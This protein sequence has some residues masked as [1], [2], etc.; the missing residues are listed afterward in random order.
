MK[1]KRNGIFE[2]NS[3]SVHTLTINNENEY[4][5]PHGSFLIVV[6]S[7][8]GR[9]YRVLETPEQKVSYLFSL[10]ATY[11]GFSYYYEEEGVEFEVSDFMLLPDVKK[12]LEVINNHDSSILYKRG[13]EG[14]G[15]VDHQS[16]MSMNEFLDGIDL[17]DFIFND[18]YSI[19]LSGD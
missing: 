11:S 2:T 8:Y 16:V 7:E 9:M 15:H 3:S 6:P 5:E 13:F 18:K 4:V 19:T 17:E 10:I 12:I 14:F 1:T